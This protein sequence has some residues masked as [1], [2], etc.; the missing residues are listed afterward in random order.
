MDLGGVSVVFCELGVDDGFEGGCG[1]GFVVGE[2]EVGGVAWDGSAGGF[3]AVGDV[4]GDF[5]WAVFGEVD[6][7]AAGA[8][9]A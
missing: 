1:A 9:F 8:A 6:A 3:G 7:D 2:V 5:S 4:F